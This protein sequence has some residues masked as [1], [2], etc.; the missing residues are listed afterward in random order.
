MVFLDGF[1]DGSGL[2]AAAEY[3][4]RYPD[5][6]V[7]CYT[8]F[9]N[10]FFCLKEREFFPNRSVEKDEF[11]NA[12]VILNAVERSFSTSI[13]PTSHIMGIPQANV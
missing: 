5:H 13:C 1:C 12:E 4:R 7:P 2:A 6:V 8:T 3:L 9:S 11:E 10:F